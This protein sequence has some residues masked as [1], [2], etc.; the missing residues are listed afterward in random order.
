LEINAIPQLRFAPEFH[1]LDGFG[2]SDGTTDSE[3]AHLEEV[4]HL[5]LQ[6]GRLLLENGADTAQVQESI[7]RFAA[8]FGY[9]AHLIVTYEAL[10]LTIVAGNQFR[11]KVGYRVPGMNVNMAAVVSV[12][13]LL[14]EVVNGRLSL[15]E[16]RAELADIEQRPT[17]YSRWIV[18]VAL[19]LTAASLARLFSS[20]W[21]AFGVAWLAG[22]AG[23]WLRQELGRRKFNLFFIPF[24]AALVSGII[25][26]AAALLGVSRTPALCLVGPAMIIV[27]GVP[28]VNGVQDMI[29][30]HMTLGLARLGLGGLVT[31]AIA[32]GL[33][34]ATVVTGAKIPVDA[35][36]KILSIPQ[37]ALFSALAAVGYLFLFNV[38]ARIAWACVVCGMASHTMR[39]LCL[40]LGIDLVSGTLIGALVVGFLA[41]GFSW[42]FRAPSA[43]F[44]FPGVVA[45]IPG[46]FAFRAVIGSL[47][48]VHAGAAAAP[49]LVTETLALA[50]ACVLMV[51][52]IAVGIAAPLILT[53]K[54]TTEPNH[55]SM[56]PSMPSKH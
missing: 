19:G 25:G 11:T 6:V 30:N 50:A 28:L 20:D 17:L 9:E 1:R 27:P 53:R 4:A 47:M 56:H 43:A 34:V 5:A 10:L 12:N 52:A 16:G 42:R 51:A 48:I 21:P 33:F 41:Q 14:G 32:F 45:M 55:L 38:P 22:S 37:D 18:V 36:L 40:H 15:A 46:A 13:R 24:A 29:K 31:V 35:P 39:T 3:P 54:G 49:V 2:V 7:V 26:G 44:A 8:A 23:M